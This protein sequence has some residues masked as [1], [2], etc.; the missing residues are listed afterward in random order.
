M[1]KSE[2]SPKRIKGNVLIG[3]FLKKTKKGFC[4]TG[5]NYNQILC[6]LRSFLAY[7]NSIFNF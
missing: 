1:Q 7:S 4:F 3:H 2:T 6:M 5:I